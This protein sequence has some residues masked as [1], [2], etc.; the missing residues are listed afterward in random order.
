MSI[1]GVQHDAW[2]FRHIYNFNNV[3]YLTPYVQNIISTCKLYKII[4]DFLAFFFIL[5]TWNPVCILHLFL[6][7]DQ[8]IA[9]AQ[10]LLVAMFTILDSADLRSHLKTKLWTK[11]LWVMLDIHFIIFLKIALIVCF[12]FSR[13]FGT[14]RFV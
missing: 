6:S 1:S 5:S 3:F 4:N 13:L 11:M 9:S 12:F 14:N 2:C 10:W 7:L 8:H